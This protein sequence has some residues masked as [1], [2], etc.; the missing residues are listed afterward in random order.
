MIQL[1][2]LSYEAS[3]QCVMYSSFRIYS[4]CVWSRKWNWKQSQMK[5]RSKEYTCFE[6]KHSNK[7]KKNR[8]WNLQ[9][10]CV[11]HWKWQQYQNLHLWCSL[12]STTTNTYTGRH[13]VPL[14]Y[15][16]HGNDVSTEN[17][18]KHTSLTW[19]IASDAVK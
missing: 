15:I 19:M 10:V 13:Y 8:M 6:T 7:A 5:R 18:I 4:T 12:L 16:A 2:F 17:P 1:I 11:W 14:I 9:L 3:K